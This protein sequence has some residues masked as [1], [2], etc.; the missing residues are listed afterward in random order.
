MSEEKELEKE[1]EE[2][3]KVAVESNL[4]AKQLRTIYTLTKTRPL[5]MVEAF[6]KHQI[7]RVS[8]TKALEM[9]LELL[10]KYDDKASFSKVLMYANMLHDYYERQAAMMYRT[11]AEECAK[12]IC[13]QRGCKYLGVDLFMER[14]R[15][16]VRVRVSDYRGDPG[17]LASSIGQE[18]SHRDPKFQ[19]KIWIEPVD[20]R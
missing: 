16:E 6:I 11:V 7:A 3:A 20:R 8:G 17:F 5:P 19:G 14:G 15:L 18:I 10:K 2:L 12:R 1:G 13:E 9:T 4:G